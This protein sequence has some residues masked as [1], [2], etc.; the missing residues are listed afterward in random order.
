MFAG[1]VI[2]SIVGF[3]AHVTKKDIADV[4]A[5]GARGPRTRLL[6]RGSAGVHVHVPAVRSQR[7]NNPNGDFLI[8]TRSWFSIPGLPGGC[9]P[10]AG[11]SSLGHSVLL[12]AAHAGDRQP[13]KGLGNDLLVG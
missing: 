1:F 9:N 13:G 4:A 10:V 2:F 8:S 5:S 3:M 11:V 7:H 12:H 6:L